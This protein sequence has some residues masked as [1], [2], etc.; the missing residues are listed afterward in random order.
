[1]S[2]APLYK[3]TGLPT[4]L[5]FCEKSRGILLGPMTA[6]SKVDLTTSEVSPFIAKPAQAKRKANK[7][8]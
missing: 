4:Q 7:K 2:A 6:F 5:L 1:V 3:H 8:T